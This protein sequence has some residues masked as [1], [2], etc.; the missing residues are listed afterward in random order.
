[1]LFFLSF[2]FLFALWTGTP[3]SNKKGFGVNLYN[4]IIELIY[5]HCKLI[6]E[7]RPNE[8]RVTKVYLQFMRANN[9]HAR[10]TMRVYGN[11]PAI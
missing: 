11:D 3:S 8:N 5:L 9:L 6:Q 10:I 1:M 4:N 2:F 7:I